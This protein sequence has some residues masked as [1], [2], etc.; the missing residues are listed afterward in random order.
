MRKALVVVAWAL[1]A[2]GCSTNRGGIDGNRADGGASCLANGECD[3][4]CAPGADPD[5][6]ESACAADGMCDPECETEDPDCA[7]GS[8]ATVF[9]PGFTAAAGTVSG[10][11]FHVRG[12]LTHLD[13]GTEAKGK[14]YRIGGVVRRQGD[15]Q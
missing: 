2:S 6:G 10:K 9:V 8:V 1:V 13:R 7:P 15:S 3:A 4:A 12:A 5:C 14:S 11:K